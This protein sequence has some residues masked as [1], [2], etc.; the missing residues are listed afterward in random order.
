MKILFF[1]LI[2]IPFLIACSKPEYKNEHKINYKTI[3]NLSCQNLK[4]TGILQLDT[5]KLDGKESSMEGEFF[6]YNDKIGF[7]D[8][9]LSSILFYDNQGHYITS[10]LSQGRGPNEVLGIDQITP[11][12]NNRF[13]IMDEQWNLFLLDS[14]FRKINQYRIN[15]NSQKSLKQLLKNPQPEDTGLYEVEYTKN[16]LRQWG[17][18]Y[19]LFPVSSDTKYINGYEGKNTGLYYSENLT[20]ALLSID[21]GK[22]EKLICNYPLIYQKQKNLVN[23]KFSLFDTYEKRFLYSYEAD[24]L[25]YCMNLGDTTITSFGIAGKDM[26]Q[27]YKQYFTLN[28]A[29]HN[30][31]KDRN[32]FGYYHSIVIDP[33]HDLVFRTYRQGEHSPYDGLQVYQQNC[34]IADYQTPK[35]FTFLG[36]IS[37]W[38]YASGP[39]DYDNEQ[40][41]IY[42]FNLNDL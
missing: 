27:N 5:L 29:S 4:A 25:I 41:I 11:I 21:S 12:T 36:Y 2:T 23:F 22:V 1:T 20:M 18:N 15:W 6:I 7:S 19:L 30:F 16:R 24:S 38:F 17:E 35:N 37:P 3:K 9:T 14:C 26:N 33:H 13:F 10:K 40:M 28:D 34:L 39:L 32:K 8:R 31:S 42:R